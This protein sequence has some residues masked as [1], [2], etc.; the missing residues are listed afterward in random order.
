MSNN[1]NVTINVITT[2]Q[3]SLNALNSLFDSENNPYSCIY[4][5]NGDHCNAE[6]TIAKIE[7]WGPRGENATVNTCAVA[8]V[9]Y[10]DSM[11]VAMINIGYTGKSPTVV[12]NS[13]I[14]HQHNV[15]ELA[16][17]LADK[18][19]NSPN[20][21]D[22]SSLHFITHIAYDAL[23]DCTPEDGYSKF[24]ITFQPDHPYLEAFLKNAGG[25]VINQ[26]NQEELLGKSSFHPERFKLENN[27][28]LECSA[29]NKTADMV[30]HEGWHDSHLCNNWVEKKMVVLNI[31]GDH[32]EA[33]HEL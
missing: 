14:D 3:A 25:A 24:I 18:Y 16:F 12:D 6:R 27:Q 28:L 13:H 8:Q 15:Y 31:A 2:D 5:G 22:L 23:Q 9:A 19:W 4:Y 11:P 10:L 21:Q 32:H 1:S 17:F 20:D 7:F 33:H 26:E 29:W 30:S